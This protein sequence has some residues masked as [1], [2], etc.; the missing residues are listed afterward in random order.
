[1]LKKT[2]FL[3]NSF[4]STPFNRVEAKSNEVCAQHCCLIHTQFFFIRVYKFFK[5]PITSTRSP[6]Y[7]AFFTQRFWLQTVNFFFFGSFIYSHKLLQ[8]SLFE[9]NT[10]NSDKYLELDNDKKRF[11]QPKSLHTSFDGVISSQ[12]Q[13]FFSH[14]KISNLNFYLHLTGICV[15]GQ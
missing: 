5:T 8:L 11:L 13:I 12:A 2:P 4:L 6:I 7:K 9:F 15:A 3:E 10:K 14:L 1:V